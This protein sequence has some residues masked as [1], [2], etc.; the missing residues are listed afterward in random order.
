MNQ[1]VCV[2]NFKDSTKGLVYFYTEYGKLNMLALFRDVSLRYGKLKG[3][4]IHKCGDMTNGC[5]SA[6]AHYDPDN[7]HHGGLNTKHRHR[8][9]LGNITLDNNGNAKLHLVDVPLTLNE[10]VGRS[11][12]L[13]QAEDDLG[14]GKTRYLSKLQDINDVILTYLENDNDKLCNMIMG[15]H[16]MLSEELENVIRGDLIELRKYQ[17]DKTIN[18]I[19]EK[20]KDYVFTKINESKKTGNSGKRIGCGVIGYCEKKNLDELISKFFY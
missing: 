5:E 3:L 7:E 4:H 16:Q 9:D 12:I 2:L 10:V 14:K 1:A 20:V 8:G 13:H 19:N 17:K 15:Y 18:K 6:C 11:V